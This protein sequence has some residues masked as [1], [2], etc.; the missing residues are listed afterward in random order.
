MLDRNLHPCTAVTN[1]INALTFFLNGTAFQ[2]HV[3]KS[4]SSPYNFTKKLTKLKQRYLSFTK[5]NK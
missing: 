4:N 5:L 1:V 3:K 2:S